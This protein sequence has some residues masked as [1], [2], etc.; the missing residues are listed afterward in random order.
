MSTQEME[1]D[2]HSAVKS[3]IIY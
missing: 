3:L 2:L 1:H